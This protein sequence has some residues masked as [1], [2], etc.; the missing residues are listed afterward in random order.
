MGRSI[1]PPMMFKEKPG[2]DEREAP[3]VVIKYPADSNRDVLCNALIINLINHN[4][5]LIVDMGYIL[6][7]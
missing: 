5:C 2:A 7:D 6:F 1:S 4:P 3:R